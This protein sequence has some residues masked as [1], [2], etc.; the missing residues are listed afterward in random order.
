M[1]AV[2]IAELQLCLTHTKPGIDNVN[3]THHGDARHI[4]MLRHCA[5]YNICLCPLHSDTS[6]VNGFSEQPFHKI[7][8]CM[9]RLID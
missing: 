3:V 1:Q 6:T 7:C 5:C 2:A 8:S 4:G 9:M